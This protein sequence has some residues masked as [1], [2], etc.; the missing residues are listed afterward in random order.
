MYHLIK[1]DSK[2]IIF[3]SNLGK[4]YTGNPKAIYE[5]MVK[6]GLDQVYTCVWIFNNPQT[7]IP[8][9]HIQVKKM[10]LKYLYYFNKAKYWIV[11]SRQPLF[12]NKKAET[13][14]IQTWHG[15]PL[16]KLALDMEVIDMG[17]ETDLEGYKDR[18]KQSSSRWDYLLAQ[19]Y[20]SAEVFRSAFGFDKNMLSMGYPRN[21]KLI[22]VDNEMILNIKL[23]LNLPIDKK[24]ILYA[25]TWRDN[26]FI[27]K[28]YYKFETELNIDYM[29]K[30]LSN[31]YI[32]IVK[33]HYLV[34]EK[35]KRLTENNKFVYDFS[36]QQD[37]TDLY[38]VS[39]LL[40]TD[41]SSVMFDYSVLKRPM[42][43]YVYDYEEYRDALRG[44]YF[45]LKAE[46]PGPCVESTDALIHEIKKGE[47]YYYQVYKDKYECFS[48]K[49]NH[50]D[51]G[52]SSD[53]IINYLLIDGGN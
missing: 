22:E 24:I 37:I 17:G 48:E 4:N 36:S 40:I 10:R 3:E 1:V 28:G 26:A 21:D 23:K 18:F 12:L 2:V 20:Y 46:A 14:F 25:P 38:L 27:K 8:G 43:F 39:D 31:D 9:K 7:V 19:N 30:E 33:A 13:I 15:T 29:S 11:D 50:L 45:D 6:R 32:L 42:Y 52:T 16:K 5:K 35:M 41:Y 49:F 53:K 47:D 34:A 51:D 44:F